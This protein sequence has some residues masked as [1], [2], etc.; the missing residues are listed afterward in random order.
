MI[1]IMMLTNSSEVSQEFKFRIE[2]VII[3]HGNGPQR[4]GILRRNRDVV[5]ISLRV[6]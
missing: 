6:P 3:V 2:R 4:T 1:V 5:P